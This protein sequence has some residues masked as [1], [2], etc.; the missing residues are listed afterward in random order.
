MPDADGRLVDGATDAVRHGDAL[1][2]VL[3]LASSRPA[4]VGA[5]GPSPVRLVCVD[6]P[7]GSGKT[8]LGRALGTEL[9]AEVLHMDDLYPGWDA[10]PA[11]GVPVLLD[12]VL[13]PLRSGRDGSYRRYDWGV[14]AYAERRVVPPAPYLVVE[15]CGAAP[16]EVDELATVVVWVEAADDVRLERGVARDGEPLRTHWTRWMDQ[17]RVFFAE[18]DTRARADVVVDGVGRVVPVRARG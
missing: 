14:G 10:G 17:E 1:G 4:L 6:G 12:Q 16:R 9:R 3:D 5:D 8:T 18:Q 7:A 13:A 15:G 2:L 11:G